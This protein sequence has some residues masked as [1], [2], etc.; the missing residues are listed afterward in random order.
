MRCRIGVPFLGAALCVLLLGWSLPVWAAK[1]IIYPPDGALLQEG[2]VEIS[3]YSPKG[4]GKA[5]L[6]VASSGPAVKK[7]VPP[8]KF[9]VTVKLS[10]GVN[11]ITFAGE[12]VR[13][14][15]AER[16]VPAEAS[17]YGSPDTHA[18]DNSCDDCHIPEWD[19]PGLAEEGGELCLMCHEDVTKDGEGEAM[20]VIHPPA[21][22]G[23]CVECH[24]FHAGSIGSLSA[25]GLMGVCF[26]CH[27]DFR[28]GDD[29][30]LHPPAEEGECLGCHNPHASAESALLTAPAG[31]VCLECHDDPGVNGDGEEWATPHPALDDGCTGCHSPHGSG[32][33]SLLLAEAAALCS[34]CHDDKNAD[35]DG[36]EWG[37]AHPPVDDGE[38]LGCHLPH[39]SAEAALLT[40]PLASLC[41]ECHDDKNADED[42][43]EWGTPHPPVEDGECAGCHLPHGSAE[44][45]LLK[46]PAPGLCN[47]CHDDKLLNSSGG[48][49]ATAHPPVEEGDCFACH[50]PHGAAE[51]SLLIKAAPELCRECHDDVRANDE[52]VKWLTSHPPVEE[53]RCGVCHKPHGT[54]LPSLLQ[55][56]AVELC[57]RCHTEM[58]EKHQ[59]S[60]DEE[61]SEGRRGVEVPDDF[62]V[63]VDGRFYCIGCHR[64]HG[65]DEE[66]L[67]KAEMAEFCIICHKM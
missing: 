31:E 22:E 43:N 6:S 57:K 63:T 56:R 47:E 53:G 23:E 26:E 13:V 67:W 9:S 16:E 4:V 14:F 40:Q 55:G 58:H 5:V 11:T 45:A 12:M 30:T 21:E 7:T 34:E 29:L 61:E 32:H 52:G 60:V 46:M 3:G 65:S 19:D 10:P 37:T 15:Y 25:E 24:A 27:D 1:L 38:C 41:G 66:N 28:E 20:A 39:G 44:A 33:G 17:A 59:V 51:S 64:P 50:R 8:G 42:G 54:T 35:E 62:P 2:T 49:W 36:N 48:E 18:L